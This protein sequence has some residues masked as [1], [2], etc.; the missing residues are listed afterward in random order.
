VDEDLVRALVLFK[1][2]RD[3]YGEAETVNALGVGYGRLGQT[4][5]A[6][7]QYRKAVELRRALGNRRGV[8]TSLRNL[9][10]VLSLTGKYDE[11]RTH[12]TEARA[13][14]AQLGDRAGLAAVD[15]ELGLLAEERGDYPQAL[16]AFRRALQ[17]WRQVGIRM[18]PPMRSTTSASRISSWAPTTTR[19]RTGSRRPM[20]SMRWA[21]TPA[22]SARQQNLGLL[23]TAR[24]RWKQ[25]RTLLTA[26]LA[27]AQQAQMP[28]EA[29]VSRR[30][31][32]ELEL[33]QGHLAAAI[34]HA[35]AAADLFRARDDRRGQS[36]AGLLHVQALL[37]A[38][39]NREAGK[40]FSSL[41]PALL[42]AS[43]EQHALAQLVAADIASRIGTRAAADNA[44]RD[45]ARL[46]QRSGVAQLQLLAALERE[47]IGGH[48]DATLDARTAAL[49]NAPLRLRWLESSM[50]SALA[51]GERAAGRD[52]TTAKPWRG[53]ATATPERR[54]A[55]SPGRPRAG[56]SG[57]YRARQGTRRRRP[58]RAAGSD[59]CSP[60]PDQG[61]RRPMN[62]PPRDPDTVDTAALLA[63]YERLLE[64]VETNEREFRRLAVRSLASRKTNAAASR[65]TC[66]TASARRSPPSSIAWCNSAT[67][68]R[69]RRANAWMP[70]SSCWRCAG[71]HRARCRACC[72]PPSST[73]SAWNP[74]CAALARS[75]AKRAACRS[76]SKSNRCPSST[77]TS[78]R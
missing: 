28:E 17:G 11:A 10:N 40:F 25:A 71:R 76:R 18:A 74:R 37:A 70:R 41:E 45:A 66:T 64:R 44:L 63:Q 12:L 59:R 35:K 9:A 75:V 29:A 62:E 48:A 46:A 14:N 8:A 22:A 20:P 78:R 49:G 31:L 13:L 58:C 55:A 69:R 57:G 52:A 27:R 67:G 5:D 54:S 51:R 73:T 60:D 26:S 21:K 36:D 50:Q 77:A 39:A 61:C 30:N 1:R 33:V 38:N 2:G 15:N 23:A 34:T 24:G 72:A 42:D 65:A 19:R 43:I 56:R 68:S 47:R 3:L 16:D 6:A 4:A 53:C 32:A 7:E